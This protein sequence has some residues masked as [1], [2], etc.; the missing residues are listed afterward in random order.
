MLSFILFQVHLNFLLYFR[1]QKELQEKKIYDFNLSP[2][3]VVDQRV[4]LYDKVFVP[5]FQR[6]TVGGEHCSGV[7]IYYLDKILKEYCLN[8]KFYV[9]L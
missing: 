3:D 8:W 4:P 2:T 9:N 1:A 7:S 5:H 6:V